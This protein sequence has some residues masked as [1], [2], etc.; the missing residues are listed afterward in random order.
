MLVDKEHKHMPTTAEINQSL[1]ETMEP[2]MVSPKIDLTSPHLKETIDP[3]L[4]TSMNPS[5]KSSSRK[6]PPRKRSTMELRSLEQ[7]SL[8]KSKPKKDSPLF[9]FVILLVLAI[10]IGFGIV[11]SNYSRG[12][13]NDLFNNLNN[14]NNDSSTVNPE[15][16]FYNGPQE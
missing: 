9:K 7:E 11:A 4:K 16:P 10:A 13:V 1:I 14:N 12:F 3:D 6:R 15:H 8:E 5:R 2:Q